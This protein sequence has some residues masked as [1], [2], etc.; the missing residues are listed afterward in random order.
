MDVNFFEKVAVI[1]GGGI[2][3]KCSS[4]PRHAEINDNLARKICKDLGV[5]SFK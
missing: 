1:R 3:L 5:K 4:V 2:Q